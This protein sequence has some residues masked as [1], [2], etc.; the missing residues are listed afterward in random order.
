MIVFQ[1]FFNGNQVCQIKFASG[2]TG[3][4]GRLAAP[5]LLLLIV[6]A[7]LRSDLA[8]SNQ[9]STVFQRFFNGNQD[10]IQSVT[11]GATP[12]PRPSVALGVESRS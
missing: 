2:L 6:S 12:V 1:R 10:G 4:L 8:S 9:E 11:S 7:H 5:Q 3:C